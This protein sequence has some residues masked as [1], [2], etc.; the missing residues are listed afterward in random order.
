MKYWTIYKTYEQPEK[1][2]HLWRVPSTYAAFNTEFYGEACRKI[3]YKQLDLSV[4]LGYALVIVDPT[5][6]DLRALKN[7]V[8]VYSETGSSKEYG[9]VPCALVI[10]PERFKRASA[11]P[12][13]N[14]ELPNPYIATSQFDI[15][16]TQFVID[17]ELLSQDGAKKR[18]ADCEHVL[19]HAAG[20]CTPH[21]Y[22]NCQHPQLFGPNA[23]MEFPDDAYYVQ[24]RDCMPAG[25]YQFNNWFMATKVCTRTDVNVSNV[26][27]LTGVY[28]QE[29]IRKLRRA[30]PRR[31]CKYCVFAKQSTGRRSPKCMIA[32]SMDICPG[33]LLASEIPYIPDDKRE[34]LHIYGMELPIKMFDD[35]VEAGEL[36]VMIQRGSDVYVVDYDKKT[37]DAFWNRGNFPLI[38]L[39]P[40][41]MLS[42]VRKEDDHTEYINLSM[43]KRRVRAP[44]QFAVRRE[45]LR[46]LDLFGNNIQW[47]PKAAYETAI[48]RLSYKVNMQLQSPPEPPKR[49]CKFVNVANRGYTPL[50]LVGIQWDLK[51]WWRMLCVVPM[52]N[53]RLYEYTSKTHAQFG[54]GGLSIFS[55]C[56]SV[57][58]EVFHNIPSNTS[59]ESV[60][61][62]HHRIATI[63][64]AKKLLEIEK[65]LQKGVVTT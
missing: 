13:I 65:E 12:L 2:R 18:C 48:A 47:A 26:S 15:R 32:S 57:L 61:Q 44:Y 53:Q 8:I 42:I 33:P 21:W 49:F 28:H 38:H 46:D 34:D 59:D 58:E 22:S 51:R 41:P 40:A 4:D 10:S 1:G 37:H 14:E 64:D 52:P 31:V 24:I 63:E 60:A 30:Q 11:W 50:R 45:F 29:K 27:H 20:M 62:R 17:G 7:A 5:E 36:R 54:L 35:I 56:E 19:D 55:D 43:V 3:D 16:S 25:K 6:D 39:S 23:K 9:S